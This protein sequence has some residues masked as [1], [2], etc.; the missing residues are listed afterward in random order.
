MSRAA[1]RSRTDARGYYL[2]FDL[3]KATLANLPELAK[4]AKLT[5]AIRVCTIF[6]T[7]GAWDRIDQL[8]ATFVEEPNWRVIKIPSIEGTELWI[9]PESKQSQVE[10]KTGFDKPSASLL[11]IPG[12][13]MTTI[14]HRDPLF[15]NEVVFAWK[16]DVIC[17][18]L[19]GATLLSPTGDW[20]LE[21][22]ENLKDLGS[23][24]FE[25]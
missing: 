18:S 4:Q 24:A 17:T 11:T 15:R 22:L 12:K 8:P 20:T 25:D 2:K 6:R 16:K 9:V 23:F 1:P 14:K 5:G 19:T 13:T 21:Q 3:A 10:M 7:H